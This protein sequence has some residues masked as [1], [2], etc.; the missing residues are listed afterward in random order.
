MDGD[1]APA[2]GDFLS[3][4]EDLSA[5]LILVRDR[6]LDI[7]A[8]IRVSSPSSGLKT[9]KEYTLLVGVVDQSI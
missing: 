9:E 4:H 7:E 3:D 8:G 6:W 5:S 2:I 1:E